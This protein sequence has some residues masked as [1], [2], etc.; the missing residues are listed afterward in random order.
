ML[1]KEERD[2]LQWL[3]R[4]LG[5]LNSEEMRLFDTCDELEAEVNELRG[6]C[7]QAGK[8]LGY[9]VDDQGI[10]EHCN[11]DTCAVWRRLKEEGEKP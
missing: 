11:C 4:N 3:Y 9:Y 5:R 8:Q 7:R 1:S 10:R 6:L 2:E